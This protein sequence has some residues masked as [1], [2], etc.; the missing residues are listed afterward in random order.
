MRDDRYADLLR[1]VE[2]PGR[3]VGGELHSDWKDPAEVDTRIC[4]CF[5]DSYEIGM[6]NL[7]MRILIGCMN[8]MDGVFCER[9]YAPWPDMEEQ[10]RKNGVPLY[11]LESG[12][13]LGQFDM[14]MFTLQ[15][16][17]CYTNVLN[18]LRL[19]NIPLRSADRTAG[20]PLIVAGGPCSYNPEP[21]AEFVD[22]FS[23]GEGEEALPE[24][25][26][27]YRECRAEGVSREEFLYR[28]SRLEGFYVPSLYTPA[29]GE[30]GKLADFRPN[31]EGVPSKV[32]K[33]IIED[34]DKV[35]FPD[36]SPVPYLDVVHDRVMLEVFR[37]C[38]RGCRFCQAGM[39]YRP[40]REKSPEVLEACAR[41]SVANSGYSEISLTSL[42]I[43]D[44][45]SLPELIDRLLPWTEPRRIGLSLPS[46]RIDAFY[47]ELMTKVMSVRKSGLTFA[48]E[49]GTQ[50]LRDVI[51]KNI[52]EE[53][54]LSACGKAFDGGRNTLK[55]YFMNGL[56]TETDDDI[57]GIA[58]LAQKIVNLFY[59]EK[60]PGRSV[61]VTVSVSCFVPKPFTP[62]QWDAQDGFEELE[63]KQALL[64]SEIRS[65]KIDY[66]YHDARVSRLEAVF[67]KGDRRIGRAIA[68][69]VERGQRFDAWDEYFDYDRWM[70]IFSDCGID[71]GFYANRPM[72]EDEILPWDFID[73]GVTKEFLL[74]ERRKSR[75]GETTPDC[76]TRCSGCGAAGLC[77]GP[78]S[79][80][81]R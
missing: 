37:G 10:L 70:E 42:S 22:I 2:K 24:L 25:V 54:I 74:R 13:P 59:S 63:R 41:A 81:Q 1:N 48:P 78:C 52:T 65:R 17:L 11:A 33:R 64:R 79:C 40:Y 72:E 23:I 47:E 66:K 8:R 68:E 28:A 77:K 80:T 12:D 16:E 50:R 57:R 76:R 58:A 4:F 5:P 43:S 73:I 56:P 61:G 29:Y 49:A 9:S 36:R 19:S 39:V 69:A 31:R 55:L 51:N 7:G 45:P 44:Y 6:S 34:L 30:D 67:A 53:E 32:R 21:M 35:Y 18:M 14:V 46:Q 3:Y 62:F 20:H 27:L 75:L 38:I 15:Y 60:R 71:P 26:T